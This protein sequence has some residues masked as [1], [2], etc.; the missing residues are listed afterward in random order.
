MYG[1]NYPGYNYG[2]PGYG[3]GTGFGGIFLII[4]V[5]FILLAI[6]RPGFVHTEPFHE[7]KRAHC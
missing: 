7:E 5:I 1:Y 6:A 4:I 3:Y 2:Y